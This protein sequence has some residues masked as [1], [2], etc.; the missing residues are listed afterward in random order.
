M[1]LSEPME[2]EKKEGPKED[3]V[4]SMLVSALQEVMSVNQP[5]KVTLPPPP[6]A[7]QPVKPSS[8]LHTIINRLRQPKK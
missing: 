8:R 6:A 1:E 3:E 5:N 2:E 4:R 7:K